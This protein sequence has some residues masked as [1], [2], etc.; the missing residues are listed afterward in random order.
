MLINNAKNK[1]M[2]TNSKKRAIICD[3]DGT[4]AKYDPAVRTPYEHEKSDQD[5]P[6]NHIIDLLHTIRR[7]SPEVNII[8]VS[9][10]SDA[11][12]S[13]TLFWLNRY[14][15]PFD[16]IFMRPDGNNIPD[17]VLKMNIYTENIE[18]AFDIWF[19]LD[20]RDR[21]VDMWRNVLHLPC[22]QV[23]PGNF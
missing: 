7:G 3:I 10:R 6:H 9:G 13:L 12:R 15:V 20:D 11:Y 16:V 4:L 18:K 8:L 22:L 14:N 1:D 23:A 21:V 17:N 19:V 5:L 2:T